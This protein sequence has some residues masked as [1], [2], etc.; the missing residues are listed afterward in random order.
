MANVNNCGTVWGRFWSNTS[1]KDHVQLCT[2][3]IEFLEGHWGQGRLWIVNCSVNRENY[4]SLRLRK[5][6][7][8][9]HPGSAKKFS[10]CNSFIENHVN[11]FTDSCDKRDK[12]PDGLRHEQYE[13][14]DKNLHTVYYIH[15]IECI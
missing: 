7:S 11:Y 2:S 15:S 8:F 10:T 12:I 3:K 14:V 13:T 6:D 9:I 5:K 1:H 4:E